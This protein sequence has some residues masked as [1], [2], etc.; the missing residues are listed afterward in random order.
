MNAS[1]DAWPKLSVD[2]RQLYSGIGGTGTPTLTVPGVCCD[3]DNTGGK[4]DGMFSD[5]ALS[6]D[7]G[8]SMLLIS[9]HRF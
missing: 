2:L 5:I 1:L 6:A 7:N 4:S 3:S 8:Q 9:G